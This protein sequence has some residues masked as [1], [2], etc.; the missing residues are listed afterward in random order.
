M[1]TLK[2]L[3]IAIL[4]GVLVLEAHSQL[5]QSLR[6]EFRVSQNQDETYDVT[7]LKENGLLVTQRQ[8]PHYG[9]EKWIF[10][11]F[12]TDLKQRW[13]TEFKILDEWKPV[14]SYHNQQYLFWLFQEA[15]NDKV[16]V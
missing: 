9:M 3:L 16:S 10:H 14:K 2:K 5:Q 1:K 15:D 7:P 11:R 12:N 4:W 8:T 6:L 13:N